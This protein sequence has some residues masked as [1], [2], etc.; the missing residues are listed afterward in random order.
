MGPRGKKKMLGKR[1]CLVW[2]FENHGWQEVDGLWVASCQICR[3][4]L[5][6]D[7]TGLQRPCF[8]H[9]HRASQCGPETLENGL[10][11]HWT[12]HE[13]SHLHRNIEDTM[14]DSPSNM[15]NGLPVQFSDQQL[16]DLGRHL[17]LPE[18]L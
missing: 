5:R 6:Q 2:F 18:G 16:I 8:A 13:F 10:A 9:K 7:A 11:A 15:R 4:D 12:C 17:G 14:T 3:F 1:A